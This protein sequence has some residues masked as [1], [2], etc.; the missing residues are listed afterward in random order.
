[1]KKTIA[2]LMTA[3]LL[4]LFLPALADTQE[5]L[6]GM[7]TETSDGYFLLNDTAHGEVRVN[8]DDTTQWEG[9]AVPQVGQYVTVAYNGIMTRS[10]PP[11]AQA[12]R[13]SL[14]VLSGVVL[15]YD[16]GMHALLLAALDLGEVLVLLPETAEAYPPGDFV[17]V[18]YDGIVTRSYPGQISAL[19]VH[20]HEQLDGV[21]TAVGDG[22]ITLGEGET[23]VRVNIDGNTRLYG[24]L[25]T[26]ERAVVYYS[27]IMALSMP[28][29]AYGEIILPFDYGNIN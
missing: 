14:Y 5:T 21:I 16:G 20:R 18:S 12:Q 28:P 29:Q 17:T 22:F 11:Q 3:L 8:Y 2:L 25:Y 24:E 7:I 23:A 26:G 13:V 19:A 4:T 9:L 15:A 6:Q 10:I 1:M 27:G